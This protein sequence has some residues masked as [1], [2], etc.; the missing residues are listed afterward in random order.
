MTAWLPFELQ[1]IYK[2]T[3]FAAIYIY[4]DP[5]KKKASNKGLY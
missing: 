5:H 3:S 2:N 4:E 1:D